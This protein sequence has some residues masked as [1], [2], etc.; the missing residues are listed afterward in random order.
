MPVPSSAG[1]ASRRPQNPRSIDSVAHGGPAGC[2]PHG[3]QR[4]AS[5]LTLA[6]LLSLIGAGLA[7]G[8]ASLRAGL[9]GE[10]IAAAQRRAL[11]RADEA[12]L[13]F[14][15]TQHRLPCPAATPNGAEDCAR[16]KGY[17]PVTVLGLDA[18]LHTPGTRTV[19]YMVY[20]K[21]DTDATK[22]ADLAGTVIN[23]YN[24]T[25][26]DAT[27]IDARNGLDMCE[28]LRIAHKDRMTGTPT[29]HAHYK[30]RGEEAVSVAYGLALPGMG[31]RSGKGEPFEDANAETAA[32]MEAPDRP[33]DASYDDFVFV[34]DFPSLASAFGCQ[35]VEYEYVRAGRTEAIVPEIEFNDDVFGTIIQTFAF[36][37]KPWQSTA[38]SRNLVIEEKP[39]KGV[40]SPVTSSVNAVAFSFSVVEKAKSQKE[41]TLK[42]AESAYTYGIISSTTGTV[43]N[44][45]STVKLIDNTIKIGEAVAK[46][47]ACLGLCVNQYVAIGFYVGSAV[48]EGV[49]L[50]FGIA[51]TVKVIQSTVE[52]RKI[53]QK[54]GGSSSQG[55]SFCEAMESGDSTMESQRTEMLSKMEEQLANME[56]DVV[57]HRNATNE[58]LEKTKAVDT[59][60]RSCIDDLETKTETTEEGETVS[61][62][63]EKKHY[64]PFLLDENNE[65]EMFVPIKDARAQVDDLQAQIEA[66]DEKIKATDLDSTEKDAEGYTVRARVEEEAKDYCDNITASNNAMPPNE[67]LSEADLAKMCEGNLARNLA[68]VQ[69]EYDTAKTARDDFVNR[70]TTAETGE[71]AAKD[72]LNS[73]LAALPTDLDGETFPSCIRANDALESSYDLWLDYKRKQAE[74]LVAEEKY[75]DFSKEV[76]AQKALPPSSSAEGCRVVAGPLQFWPVDQA[77]E[78]LRQVDER[79]SVQ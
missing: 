45:I 12:I 11:A 32:E 69:K 77:H 7:A 76:D 67:Q 2:R 75:K 73:A 59:L 33:H 64:T 55:E 10:E 66:E 46:A 78:I 56:N 42:S 13:G 31:D 21:A 27:L 37:E 34:R 38:A 41:S 71:T 68:S 35:P 58:A 22:N 79:G 18:M 17:L 1:P 26:K 70:K 28:T 29:D 4:G 25:P 72:T 19:R 57:A 40:I 61:R 3:A 48:S 5:L 8:V 53:V 39:M 54:L 6:L 20:R 24:P 74:T 43:G 62:V 23:A 50:G 63:D 60:V 14:A 36:T 52:F 15:S 65:N 49:A 16:A 51:N 47:V 9:P 44:L 30:R